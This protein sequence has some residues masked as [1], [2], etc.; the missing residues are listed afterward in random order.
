MVE[1][2]RFSR[3]NPKVNM[4]SFILKENILPL[5]FMWFF[6]GAKLWGSLMEEHLREEE[7]M[8]PNPIPAKASE[9][10]KSYIIELINQ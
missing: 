2:F 4:L 1:C 3:K 6:M 8:G 5:M 9:K 7:N 10:A